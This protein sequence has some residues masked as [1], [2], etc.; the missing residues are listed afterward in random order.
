MLHVVVRIDRASL[1]LLQDSYLDATVA[2]GAAGITL[3]P[4]SAA[5]EGAS[6]GRPPL[7]ERV[8][9]SVRWHEAV[10][11]CTEETC[12][13]GYTVIVTAE[14]PAIPPAPL[15]LELAGCADTD[16]ELPASATLELEIDG[17]APIV[18]ERRY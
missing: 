10:A 5:H 11:G 2:A 7:A 8:Y 18:A 4:D 16:V 3:L 6:T 15:T 17:L 9:T 14:D 13:V 12:E 1:A